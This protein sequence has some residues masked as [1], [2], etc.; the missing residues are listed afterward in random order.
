VRRIL[1]LFVKVVC[2]K[3][4]DVKIRDSALIFHRIRH[5]SSCVMVPAVNTARRLQVISGTIVGIVL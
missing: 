2:M 3:M 5:I 1:S 4:N